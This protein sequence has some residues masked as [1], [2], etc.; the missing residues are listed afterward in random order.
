MLACLDHIRRIPTKSLKDICLLSLRVFVRNQVLLVSRKIVSLYS[1]QDC[2]AACSQFLLSFQEFIFSQVLACD[3][4][5]VAN[6]ILLGVEDALAIKKEEYVE[7]S[8][9]NI[10]T[11]SNEVNIVVR[12]VELICISDLKK[13]SLEEIPPKLRADLLINIS[14]MTGLRELYLGY[15]SV[16]P[17]RMDRYYSDAFIQMRHLT[18]FSL[19]RNCTDKIIQILSKAS[20]Y[21][22]QLLDVENSR[23]VTDDSVQY[24][25]IFRL[26]ELNIF[27]CSIST[28]L[29]NCIS[30]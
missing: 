27:N 19:K 7:K 8:S 10:K 22:L 2:V 28:R 14:K 18:H 20:P 30:F 5:N 16:N 29:E 26:K 21:S 25:C 23:D 13:L 12:F 11:F 17:E 6:E 3:L 4:Q 24:I 1:T 9:L 15:G